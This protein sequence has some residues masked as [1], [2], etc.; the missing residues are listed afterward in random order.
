[1]NRKILLVDDNPAELKL[2]SRTLQAEFNVATATC[3]KDGLTLL[4]THG[5]F[6]AVIS[7]MQMEQM[8]GVQF[9]LR[10]RQMAP[11]TV[12]LLLTGHIDLKG[13]VDAINVGSIFRLLLKPCERESLLE[14]VRTAVDCY[15]K[16]DEL[17]VHITL[18]VHLYRPGRGS[19]PQEAHTE[20][21]SPGGVRLAGLKEPLEKD[22]VL[23]IEFAGRSAPYRVAW[24]GDPGTVSEREAGLECLE[25]GADLWKLETCKVE[26]TAALE[27]ARLVQRQLLP[28]D[29]PALMTLDY[30]GQ[31]VQ[32]HMVG[33]DYYDFLD[34]G[35]GEVGFALGDVAGKGIPAA[36]LMASLQGS[37]HSLSSLYGTTSRNL[38]QLLTSVNLH[39]YKHTLHARYVTFFLG[40]YSDATRTLR[41]VNCGHNPPV[42]LRRSG[43]VERLEATATVLGLFPDWEC[44]I[45]SIKFQTDDV[46]ALYTD[47]IS[48]TTGCS[49]EEF[50]VV[51]LL[52]SL[53]ADRDLEAAEIAQN[54]HDRVEKYR[55]G[56]Q[57]DDVTV[58]VARGR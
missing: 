33:G 55:L 14:A 48:E 20:D 28:Q 26:D 7:D 47:G 13:S 39:L 8:D 52:E 54:I 56:E 10:V 36:L 53:R 3:G 24:M 15:S 38:C 44:S 40:H 5:P 37:L 50:G 17:R 1:M 57:K 58:V 4:R 45:S 12:R 29:R 32:A 2:Y 42:L 21:V 9:L 25:A 34:M 51:G 18:P 19:K 16:R 31:C 30:A 23:E 6:A 46:L 49:G 11:S 35:P 41:Y 43:E 22:E 27:R